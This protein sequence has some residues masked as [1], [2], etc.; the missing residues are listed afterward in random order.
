MRSRL[1]L[2]L[3][4]SIVLLLSIACD[5]I[6]RLRVTGPVP[7]APV[8]DCVLESLDADDRVTEPSIVT[9]GAI[10][11]TLVVPPSMSVPESH[12]ELSVHFSHTETWGG[13][14]EIQMLWVG[15]KASRE[16]EQY[17]TNV[18]RELHFVLTKRCVPPS[19]T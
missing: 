11:A 3:L 5:P 15:P 4:L 16:Y 17:A 6:Y 2:L 18:I 7:T 8:P 9:P 13:D 10:A 12:P 1:S 14:L 19:A